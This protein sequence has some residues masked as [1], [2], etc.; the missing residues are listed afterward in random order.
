[1]APAEP[2]Y[3]TCTLG[4]AALARQRDCSGEASFSSIIDVIDW[5]AEHSTSSPA[6][7]FA[8]LGSKRDGAESSV[9]R[10]VTFGDL[11]DLS[12]VAAR[13][14]GNHISAKANGGGA[15]GLLCGSSLEF[16]L[17][18]LGLLRLA[19][20]VL[21][22]APQ[23]EPRAI[24]HLCH[25]LGAR[26]VIHDGHHTLTADEIGSGIEILPVPAYAAINGSRRDDDPS[27]AAPAVAGAPLAEPAFYFHTSGTSTGLPSPI[28]QSHSMVE[29]LPRFRDRRNQPAT[30]STT[31]LYHGGLADCLRA[32]TSGALIWFFPEGQSP[33]TARN[34]T[35][36]VHFARRQ[37]CGIPLRLFSSVPYVLQMLA[38]DKD[39]ICLLLSM[40]LVG[41]GG[42]AMPIATGD[43]LVRAGVNL[44]S[45]FGS[46]ECG[47][48][49]SSHRDYT[50]DKEWEYLRVRVNAGF[51]CF[52]PREDGLS[53]LVVKPKWPFRSKT[54]RDDGSY[55]TSDLFEPHPQTANAWRYHSRADSQITLANGKKFDPS[56]I[57]T[58]LQSA[59]PLLQDAY[60]FGTGKPCAGALLFPRPGAA[61]ES[62]LAA[63]R[64][65]LLRLKP[66]TPPMHDKAGNKRLPKSSKGSILRHQADAKYASIIE[67]AY[68]AP[69]A[70]RD[71]SIVHVQ[72]GD[73]PVAVSDCFHDVLHRSVDPDK[74]LYR[75]GVDSI[76]CIQIRKLIE[77][78]SLVPADHELPLNVIYDQ[79]T[80]TSL[81][82]YLRRIRNERSGVEQESDR[83]Q[84]AYMKSLARRYGLS[85]NL[86]RSPGSLRRS[87]V[88]LLTGATGFLGAY[89]LGLL[90]RRQ[91]VSRIYCL[92][93]ASTG[94]EA[95]DRVS[96][97]QV[98]RGFPA[99]PRGDD[100]G[101]AP[102]QVVCLPFDSA[103]D[104][105][106]LAAGDRQMV[107]EDTTVI[108]HGAWPVNF[109]LPLSSFENQFSTLSELLALAVENDARLYFISSVA[110][111]SSTDAPSITERIS[112]DP[113]HASALGYARSKWVA[114][115]MCSE[116]NRILAQT[117]SKGQPSAAM[118]SVIRIGQLCGDRA[119]GAWNGSEAYPLMLSASS[120]VGCLPDLPH[121][122]TNW[123]PVD[124]AASA[125]LEI[126]ISGQAR[127]GRESRDGT[128][129]A[130]AGETSG[131][132]LATPVYHVANPD[133]STSWRQ[134]LH[135]IAAATSLPRAPRRLVVVSPDVWVQRLERDLDAEHPAHGLLGFW[136]QLFDGN[137]CGGLGDS[138]QIRDT[139]APQKLPSLEVSRARQAAESMGAVAALDRDTTL[140]L[141]SWIQANVGAH[142]S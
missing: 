46:A 9:C 108:I 47:F 38:E 98:R 139:E 118:A 54:N 29:A 59:T 45:R 117:L 40:D 6:I 69:R 41:V 137:R 72:A 127:D 75:Q 125:V 43:M 14:L 3:F 21:L 60:V 67:G 142:H 50:V 107:V 80:V 111:A 138:G 36:A 135:W 7:G 27:G 100:A 70:A 34:I 81:V 121:E 134:M 102:C 136:K 35:E 74:D 12:V 22:L 48:L 113:S 18:W 5:Q 19:H 73:L 10:P 120:A 13:T 101:S 131:G 20:P 124:V 28:P 44:L 85:P 119:T 15:V 26:L 42:A 2:K 106:E 116:A 97:S 30:F 61:S 79:G 89:L 24:E 63:I 122:G 130:R 17:T 133:A 86:A 68:E 52:E 96:E 94:E 88:V 23:L 16:V 141:W 65:V 32:W 115:R 105:L 25:Q 104:H 92:V 83:D 53:E 78:K 64:P 1:M 37:N 84:L 51:L 82:S 55:A 99:L 62:I 49:L 114:E 58:E 39:G 8:D 123:L 95:R 66:E 90:R 76:A 57:E 112:D 33:M 11:G 140:R 93:R 109:T 4:E 103:R 132:E 31:P 128:Y 71:A 87:N 56:P 110:A 129:R 91:G 77:A 126:A